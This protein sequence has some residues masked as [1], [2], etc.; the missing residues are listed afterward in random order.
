MNMH[1][2][3]KNEFDTIA[4]WE[5]LERVLASSYF[6][7]SDRLSH[8][9]R[10][11]VSES[12]EGRAHRIKEYTVALEVFD[13]P[14]DFDSSVDP[15][16]RT[17]AARLRVAL[18]RFYLHERQ[19]H[20]IQISLPKGTYVPTFTDVSVDRAKSPS[21]VA[22]NIIGRLSLPTLLKYFAV[23]VAISMAVALIV[24]LSTERHTAQ[25]NSIITVV[26]KNTSQPGTPGNDKII[27]DLVGELASYENI[28]VVDSPCDAEMIDCR[29]HS[30]QN[31]DYSDNT[32]YLYINKNL[33]YNNFYLSIRLL[34]APFNS[35]VDSNDFKLSPNVSSKLL[36]KEIAGRL[37]GVE[38]SIPVAIERLSDNAALA[39]MAK[40]DRAA[41]FLIAEKQAEALQCLTTLARDSPDNATAWSLLS[42]VSF[43]ASR[44]R[45]SLGMDTS[46]L[47]ETQRKA[48]GRAV[49]LAPD[50]YYAT[51][52]LMLQSYQNEQS[53]LFIRL[54]DSI[55]DKFGFDQFARATTAFLLTYTGELDRAEKMIRY[56]SILPADVR[57]VGAVIAYIEYYRGN[58]R[59]FLGMIRETQIGNVYWTHLLI[60][61]ASVE[62]GDYDGARASWDQIAA[63]RPTYP[64]YFHK[65]CRSRHTLQEYCDRIATNL[66]KIGVDIPS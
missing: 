63:N 50:S 25:K 22:G 7:N 12:L 46:Q 16:V 36:A 29:V 5:E 9:L 55:D 64:A 38:G 8:F 3:L 19:A 56:N 32:F 52:A 4:A 28:I 2:H 17:T 61:S 59:K 54:R 26:V 24:W 21:P 30:T 45:S 42:Y 15:I 41:I 11:I 40:A 48:T 57:K 10:Y 44:T 23:L 37:L 39:C 1:S 33:I 20:A 43:W 34:Y 51:R 60:T 35:L 49:I 47:L 13:R 58:Y 18:E 6:A 27:S 31:G 53:D 66:A 14:S 65:D 62:V